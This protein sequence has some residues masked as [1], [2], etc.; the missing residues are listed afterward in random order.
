M[1]GC[2]QAVGEQGL[3]V[4][5]MAWLAE[6]LPIETPAATSTASAARRSRP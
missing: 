5:R 2:V 4:G 1:C 6:G 3:N